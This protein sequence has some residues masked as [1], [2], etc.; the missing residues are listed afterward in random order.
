[1]KLGTPDDSGRARPIKIDGSDFV[2]DA[3]IVIP[4]IGQ[5][6]VLDFLPGNSM[7]V[8]DQTHE[9]EFENVFAGGDASRGASSLIN[10]IGDGQNVAVQIV[11]R[12]GKEKLQF[13]S[14]EDNRNLDLKSLQTR[15]ARRDFGPGLPEV[16]PE[17]R[18]NFDLFMGTLSDQEAA[19]EAARC[20]QC[21]LVCNVCT[22][23]CPNRSNMYYEIKSTTMPVERAELVDGKVEIIQE[24]TVE[25][26]QNYQ[27]INIGDY[28]NECGNCT[29]FCPTSGRPF[30]DKPKFHLTEESF[31][32][33]NIGFFFEDESSMKIKNETGISVL[34]DVDGKFHY[35]DKDLSV[36]LDSIR[37]NADTVTFKHDECQVRD[38]SAIAQFVVLYKNV[39]QTAPFSKLQLEMN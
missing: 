2:I 27:I 1:M 10:A 32:N 4:A 29:T 12:S 3:D 7:M 35:E 13:H 14:P 16:A 22:T 17:D 20:L 19:A 21:D 15:Q 9:T 26:S 38:L 36:V 18:I 5:L 30:M 39:R 25:I 28:C 8:N 34:K 33:A 37:L 11:K 24:S 31:N 23:V 6:V